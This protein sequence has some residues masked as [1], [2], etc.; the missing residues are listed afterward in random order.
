MMNLTE[1]LR[2]KQNIDKLEDIIQQIC[3]EVEPVNQEAS[4]DFA[5]NLDII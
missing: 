4:K 3:Q 5:E 2:E 1:L